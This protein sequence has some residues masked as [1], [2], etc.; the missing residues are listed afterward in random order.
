MEQ[1]TAEGLGGT[2]AEASERRR[3]EALEAPMVGG[4]ATPWVGGSVRST[5]EARGPGSAAA[6]VLRWAAE[7]LV[8]VSKSALNLECSSYYEKSLRDAS[9]V[10]LNIV[11]PVSYGTCRH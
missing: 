1:T 4:W 2:S 6:S 9:I 10:L 11:R 3:A 5:A 8:S 7:C